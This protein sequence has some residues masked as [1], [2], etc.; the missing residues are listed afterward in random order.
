[1]D[2]NMPR[3]RGRQS[4]KEVVV[5]SGILDAE[6]T[7]ASGGSAVFIRFAGGFVVPSPSLRDTSPKGGGKNRHAT[8]PPKGETRG[9][10]I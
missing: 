4:A 2:T 8:P 7:T 10:A 5:D 9:N 6:N 1:M 3:R